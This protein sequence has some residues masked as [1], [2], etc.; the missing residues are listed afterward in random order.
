MFEGPLPMH[1]PGTTALACEG[2]QLEIQWPPERPRGLDSLTTK[3][4]S[5]G[6]WHISLCAVLTPWAALKTI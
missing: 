4:P 3:L 5:S 6:D 2:V 1:A